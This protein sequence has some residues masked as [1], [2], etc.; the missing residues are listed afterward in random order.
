MRYELSRDLTRETAWESVLRI[1]CGKGR[2]IKH[3]LFLFLTVSQSFIIFRCHFN[4][5]K[6]TLLLFFFLGLRFTSYH[7]HFMLRSADL[8]ALPAVDCDKAFTMQLALEE[9]LLTTQKV[10][11][12]VAL[13][14][15][16]IP[17]TDAAVYIK[18]LDFFLL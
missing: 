17:G 13:L 15:P 5:E 3:L 8:L 10:Y 7:G 1:R 12:Q 9:T 6:L 16:F 4:T 2:W 18:M 11:F 14:Y